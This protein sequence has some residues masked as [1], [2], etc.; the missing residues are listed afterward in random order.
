MPVAGEVVGAV[1][2]AAGFT[3]GVEAGEVA[4]GVPGEGAVVPGAVVPG[5]VAP[6]GG[7]PAGVLCWANAMLPV[8]RAQPTRAARRIA[9]FGVAIEGPPS[10]QLAEKT[11]G[12]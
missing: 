11:E 4:A 3:G 12:S 6:V 2:S 1:G 9:V 10:S 7:A 5:T 8:A